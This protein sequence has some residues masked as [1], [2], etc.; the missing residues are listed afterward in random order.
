MRVIA[1]AYKDRPLDREVVGET[2]KLIYVANLSGLNSMERA[3]ASGVGFPPD[4]IFQ[5]D[6]TLFDSLEEA[7]DR[8]DLGKLK[9]LWSRAQPVR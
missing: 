4:C 5:F 1:M 6:E 3:A 9:E 2:D 8:D 7:W